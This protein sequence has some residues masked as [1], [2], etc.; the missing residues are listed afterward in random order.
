[1]L[2]PLPN[3]S[4]RSI[5]GLNR[6]RISETDLHSPGHHISIFQTDADFPAAIARWN[7]PVADF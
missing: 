7:N 2:K 1:L 6:Q 3:F 5:V 4:N